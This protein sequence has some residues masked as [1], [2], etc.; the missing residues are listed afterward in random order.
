LDADTFD[1]KSPRL[2]AREVRRLNYINAQER[3]NEMNAKRYKSTR[4]PRK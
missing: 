1:P 3:L 2:T 4:L